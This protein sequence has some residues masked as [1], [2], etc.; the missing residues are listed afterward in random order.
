MAFFINNK[1]KLFGGLFIIVYLTFLSMKRGAIIIAVLAGIVYFCYSVKE[2][3]DKKQILYLALCCFALLYFADYLIDIYS[4]NTF[5]IQRFEDLLNGQSSGRD[6]IYIRCLSLFWDENTLL[7]ILT[8][9]GAF[10][11]CHY[12]GIMAH[13][14]WLEILID[15]G[16]IGLSVYIMYWVSYF[17]IYLST[18]KLCDEDVSI[19]ILMFGLVY[20]TKSLFSMSIM[21]MPFYSTSV[22]GYAMAKYAMCKRHAIDT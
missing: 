1:Y 9:N 3:Y 12:I 18:K 4:S 14:D 16:I 8:G 10:A 15:C 5:F 22:L 21:S 17:R 11:T 13:N 7:K 20:F 6:S 2:K 19:A